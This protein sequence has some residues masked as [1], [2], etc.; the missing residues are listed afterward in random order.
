MNDQPMEDEVDAIPAAPPLRIWP[1][2]LLIAAIPLFMFVPGLFV[3]RTMV[4]FISF[5]LAPIVGTLA[6]LGWWMFAARVRG[7]D[8]WLFP[9]LILGPTVALSATLFASN[10]MAIPVYLLPIVT[11]LWVVAAAFTHQTSPEVR[12]VILSAI[13]ICSWTTVAMLRFEGAD[14]D[15]MPTFRWR[16]QPTEEELFLAERPGPAGPLGEEK[17]VMIQPGDW[18]GF[19]GPN[20]DSK[21]L[22][23][24]IETDWTAHPPEL[25]WKHRI[26]PGWGSFAV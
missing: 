19:R 14:G 22:G 25:V 24:S 2:L 26:G 13:L 23:T 20:R 4:H 15:L 18:P 10:P 8:R 11:G 12:R 5:F 9:L 17:I 16:W 3:P 7:L 21:L 6:I 1:G